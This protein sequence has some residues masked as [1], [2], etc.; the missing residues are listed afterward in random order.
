MSLRVAM[1][2]DNFYP[3]LGGIQDSI[4]AS[5][6]ELGARGHRI[7]LY[8]PA[9]TARDYE[10]IRLPVGEPELGENVSICRL[11]SVAIP[12]S[13]QQSRL[14]LRGRARWRAV[15]PFR[16]DVAHIHTFFGVGMAGRQAARRLRLPLV[17]TNHWSVGAFD[18]YVP[19]ARPL[20]RRVSSTW[21]AHY[22][23]CCDWVTAPSRFTI[24]EMRAHGL[25]RPVSVLSNPI[26]THLFSPASRAEKRNL[27][28]RFSLG[29][30][31]I[32]YAGRL[33]QEKH[34]DILIRAVARV[35]HVFPDVCLV[36]AGHGSARQTLERLAHQLGIG[37]RVLFM[38]TL[39]HRVLAQVLAASDVFAIAST[40]ET[41]SMVLLQAMACALPAVGARSGGLI[42]HISESAG[43][44]AQPGS[45]DDF[46]DKLI[47][48]LSDD[49][50]RQSMARQ[51]RRFTQEFSIS[52]VAD[53]WEALYERVLAEDG[54]G[55][56]A[57][58][59]QAG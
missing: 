23:Q 4:L 52:R 9:A 43:L 33:G 58:R 37:Q 2:S 5:A 36:I 7:R 44:Q 30:P 8:A 6:R 40:S 59:A 41:Q 17:G 13:S 31:V 16:P 55:G 26:D 56:V 25:K 54:T 12:S 48:V 50:L 15:A 28:R 35:R 21:V 57:T 1:F 27:K 29:S 19:F 51:A 11:P 3:E 24:D 39:E 32:V 47:K 20:F 53:A 34:V 49:G 10:R 14:V 45:A 46:K 18:V 38:G 42:E 22:Y